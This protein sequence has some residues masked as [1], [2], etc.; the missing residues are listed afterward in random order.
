MYSTLREQVPRQVFTPYL[1]TGSTGM[2]VYVRTSLAPEQVFGAI[3]RS[4]SRMDASLPVF[5]MRTMDE[6]IDRSLVTE[7]MIA[8]LSAVFGIVA[9]LL[10]TVGLY[11]VMAY[12]VARKTREIGIRMALGAFG[13]DVV[14]MVMREVFLL[15]A[16]GVSVGL[17]AAILLTRYI[18][19]QLFGL[20]PTDPRT[21]ALAVFALIAVA[22]A[23][24]Y[25]PAIRASRVNPIL[26]LR[27]E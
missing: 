16:I 9:T 8:M 20:T 26:A 5:D 3:R 24:G 6:Q 11:G 25:L 14:W 1:Q 17:V 27:Y 21:L 13:K 2:N 10:A 22:A 15:I 4:V 23:A 7:R 18:E 19:A 12:T